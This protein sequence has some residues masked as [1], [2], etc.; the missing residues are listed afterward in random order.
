MEQKGPKYF[1]TVQSATTT[2][3]DDIIPKG[4]TI[5][6]KL[7]NGKVVA[8]TTSE[9]CVPSHSVGTNNVIIT[10]WLPKG[11]VSKDVIQQLSESETTMIRMN[12]GGKD[13]D[14]P[15]ASGKAG[16]KMMEIA[17]CLLTD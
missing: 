17:K 13:F 15:E 11:E 8:M 1:I 4:S 10:M 9:D 12:I 16:R 3:V 2:K 6:F 14:S 7:D 5:S